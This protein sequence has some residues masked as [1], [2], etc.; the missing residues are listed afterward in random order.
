M[1]YSQCCICSVWHSVSPAGMNVIIMDYPHIEE[2]EKEN[3]AEKDP[4]LHWHKQARNLCLLMVMNPLLNYILLILK[5]RKQTTFVSVLTNIILNSIV[6][7]VKWCLCCVIL[8]FHENLASFKNCETAPVGSCYH[9]H[10]VDN[11]A[12]LMYI[13][14]G[15]STSVHHWH[16][17]SFWKLNKESMFP[18]HSTIYDSKNVW[19]VY[20]NLFWCRT[21]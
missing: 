14:A 15:S 4:T 11:I 8:E 6:L 13:C 2:E 19:C 21:H 16:L 3:L 12:S 20:S 10:D 18:K 7:R 17:S 1:L 9:Y 5:R